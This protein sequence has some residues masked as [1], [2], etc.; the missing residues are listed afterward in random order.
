MRRAARRSAGA[1]V[2]LAAVG[3][4]G[5]AVAGR[6]AQ[7]GEGGSP[8][9]PG[10]VTVELGIHHSTFDTTT[11]RV[12][13]GTTVRFVLDNG[14]PIRH[15]LIVG[16]PAV[17]RR[18][19]TGAEASHPPRPGEVSVEPL[20]AASTTYEFDEPGLVEFACHLPGHV[21]YGMVGTVEVLAA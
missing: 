2:L 21:A 8:L 19:E 20:A 7:A 4:A 16:P 3:A 15:E 14:D 12:R 17:H 10:T 6:G 1:G 13:E 11:L 18:H 9:G 5:L